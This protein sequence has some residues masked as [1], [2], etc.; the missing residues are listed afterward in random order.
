MAEAD[1]NVLVDADSDFNIADLLL[2]IRIIIVHSVL[3]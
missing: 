1:M 2:V 3:L